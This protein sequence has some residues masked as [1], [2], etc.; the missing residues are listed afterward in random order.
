MYKV[1]S[2]QACIVLLSV[3]P[4]SFHSFSFSFSLFNL[5]STYSFLF[6]NFNYMFANII[7]IVCCCCCILSVMCAPIA[8]YLWCVSFFIPQRINKFYVGL[9]HLDN[10]FFQMR[11]NFKCSPSFSLLK[12]FCIQNDY[13]YRVQLAI[14]RDEA[15]S[16]SILL[17]LI[18][19]YLFFCLLLYLLHINPNTHTHTLLWSTV[20][21]FLH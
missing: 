11:I 19:F 15:N 13:D 8:M 10:E 4:F 16:S 6:L 17:F 12:C 9:M 1:N 2:I 5:F 7:C 3:V 20:S 18:F 21:E 14:H